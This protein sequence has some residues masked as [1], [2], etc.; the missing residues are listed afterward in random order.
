MLT[1]RGFQDIFE[2]PVFF[3]GTM[4]A[5]SICQGKVG[6]CWFLAAIAALSANPQLLERLCVARHEQ[7]GVY[8]F[9]FFRGML[10]SELPSID[11]YM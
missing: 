4:S 1:F 3:E 7:V 11:D 5:T 10:S 8:G 2:D 9:V 6:D